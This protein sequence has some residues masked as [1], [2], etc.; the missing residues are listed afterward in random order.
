MQP[1]AEQT[2]NQLMQRL[3]PGGCCLIHQQTKGEDKELWPVSSPASMLGSAALN[4]AWVLHAHALQTRTAA[5]DNLQ[6]GQRSSQKES[7]S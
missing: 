2:P 4:P 1:A 5:A 6:H 7:G 3:H